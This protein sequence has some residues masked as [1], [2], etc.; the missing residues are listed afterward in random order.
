MLGLESG[1]SLEEDKPVYLKNKDFHARK[2]D[3]E[4]KY[5]PDIP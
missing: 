4:H 1:I 5:T 3:P 2:I